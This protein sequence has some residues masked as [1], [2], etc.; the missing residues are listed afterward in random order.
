MVNKKMNACKPKNVLH[1]TTVSS[2]LALGDSA[3]PG[4]SLRDGK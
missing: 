3:V 4:L 1:T 2:E